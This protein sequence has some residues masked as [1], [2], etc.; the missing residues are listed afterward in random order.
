MSLK[1]YEQIFQEAIHSLESP[2]ALKMI[3]HNFENFRLIHGSW[4][5]V[6]ENKITFSP[7]Y[8]YWYIPEHVILIGFFSKY[9]KGR[10]SPAP[11][12]RQTCFEVFT[13]FAKMRAM[14]K[15]GQNYDSVEYRDPDQWEEI[16]KTFSSALHSM[17]EPESYRKI[18]N[19]PRK[20]AGYT[21]KDALLE[22]ISEHSNPAKVVDLWSGGFAPRLT[23]FPYLGLSS[24]SDLP[25]RVKFFGGFYTLFTSTNAYKVAGAQSFAPFLQNNPFDDLIG[26]VDRWMNGAS[27]FDNPVL[28]N[29][30]PKKNVDCTGYNTIIELYGFIR[31]TDYPFLNKKNM[32]FYCDKFNF[33]GNREN[34]AEVVNFISEIG[35]IENNYMSSNS[36]ILDHLSNFYDQNLARNSGI[37]EYGFKLINIERR[38]KGQESFKTEDERPF[39]SASLYKEIDKCFSQK[40]LTQLE[41]AKV[42]LNLALDANAYLS[43]SL[44]TNATDKAAVTPPKPDSN[45]KVTKTNVIDKTLDETPEE[46]IRLTLPETLEPLADQALYCLRLGFHVLFAGP[47]GTGKTTLAQFVGYAWNNHLAAIPRKILVANA[48]EVTVAHSGWAAFHTIGGIFPDKSGGYRTVPGVFIENVDDDEG[49][50]SL[51]SRAIVLDEMNRA[52]L[53]RSIGELYPLLSNSVDS[54]IP[55]GIPGIK[56][57]NRHPQFR[58]IATVND[59]SLDD[60]VFPISEGLLRRFQ[61][62]DLLGGSHKDIDEYFKSSSREMNTDKY[63]AAINVVERLFEAIRELEK[64]HESDEDEC[65]PFGVGYFAMLKEWIYDNSTITEV[66][67]DTQLED[68]A[69]RILISS[70]TSALRSRELGDVITKLYQQ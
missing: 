60:I 40:N 42:V 29:S 17:K 64:L 2:D 4:R 38:K 16:V 53:D 22:F 24:L 44:A 13:Y 63:S 30:Y 18:N 27:L 46:K 32:A 34:K 6:H 68:Q 56:S 54:V 15:L 58:I 3:S 39:D 57:I 51:K 65:L 37:E 55:A 66:A 12:L 25:Q 11:A 48:P 33:T 69:V 41:K 62:I 59:A 1:S 31:L 19:L 35:Q 36:Q 43:N 47:P 23:F 9:L 45:D 5:L 52:D 49:K 20:L 70:V 10:F 67:D 8:D 26:H 28:L 7:R 21:L 14:G 61:R 50:W